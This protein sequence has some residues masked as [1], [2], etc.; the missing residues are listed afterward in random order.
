MFDKLKAT[1]ARREFVRHVLVLMSTSTLAQLITIAA[2]PILSRLYTPT[3]MGIYT[4]FTSFVAGL[5]TITT[6][7]YSLATVLPDDEKDARALVKLSRRIS[8]WVCLIGGLIL[9]IGAGPI[10]EAVRRPEMRFWLPF[11]GLTAWAYAQVEIYSYWCNRHRQY[12]LMGTNRINQASTTSGS[13]LVLGF[14]G[15]GPAGMILPVFFG[16][17][18]GAFTMWLKT[19]KEINAQ[20]IGSMKEMAKRYRK[21]PLLSMPTAILDA[22]RQQGT[23]V[24]I[25]AMF[26]A[27]AVGQYGWAWRLLQTPAGLI[28]YSLSQVFYKSL[29]TTPRGHMVKMVTQS[30]LRSALIG[31][32]PFLAI[33]FLSPPLFPIIFGG[34]WAEAGRIGAALVPWLYVNFITSPVSNLFLVTGRQGILMWFALPL[35]AAPF[36]VLLSFHSDIVATAWLLSWTMTGLLLVFLLLALWVSWQYDRGFGADIDLGDAAESAEAEA[37]AEDGRTLDPEAAADSA[38]DGGDTPTPRKDDPR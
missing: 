13:Q 21:M 8:A 31:V 37:G 36:V 11:V 1:L 2:S 16:Q 9:L 14:F 18:A 35:T 6:G 4:V 19:R 7:R 15:V 24:M 22:V 3:E 26:S 20:P 5:C 12:R 28:N 23:P 32:V 34:Q 17:S 38:T 10:S 33:Y 29:A 27:A 25:S 30:I